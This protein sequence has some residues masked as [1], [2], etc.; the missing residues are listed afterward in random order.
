MN[1]K[2]NERDSRYLE[3]PSHIQSGF[4]FVFTLEFR[5]FLFGGGGG[6][7]LPS[8]DAFCKFDFGFLRIRTN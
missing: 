1:V 7:D 2:G 4:S 6:L 5:N 3:H 8:L